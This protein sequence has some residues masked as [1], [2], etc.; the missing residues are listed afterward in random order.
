VSGN[1]TRLLER[2]NG[3]GLVTRSIGCE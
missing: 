1:S 3:T 2:A